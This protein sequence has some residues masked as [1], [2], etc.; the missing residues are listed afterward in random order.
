M[1]LM[2]ARDW[3]L[4]FHQD[5]TLFTDLYK[6]GV[7]KIQVASYHKNYYPEENNGICVSRRK[8]EGDEELLKR[9]RKK[10]S[11]SGIVKEH[12]EKMYFEKPSDKRRRKKAQSIRAF[13]KEQEKIKDSRKKYK[14]DKQRRIRKN[15]RSSDRQNRSRR[16]EKS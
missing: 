8:G 16:D 5:N 3:V 1:F 12:R 14:K 10:L 7:K 15:A 4:I 2:N 11:K 6:E 13:K 9:F